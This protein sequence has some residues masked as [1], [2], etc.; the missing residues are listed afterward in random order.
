MKR[1]QYL[2]LFL[3]LLGFISF[4]TISVEIRHFYNPNGSKNQEVLS[5]Q[6]PTQLAARQ[7]VSPSFPSVPDMPPIPE[8][9][10]IAP[11]SIPSIP[12]IPAPE[13]PPMPEIPSMPTVLPPP[14]PEPPTV[15]PIEPPT[16]IIPEA[17]DVPSFEPPTPPSVEIP[18]IPSVPS[19]T[20]P[21]ITIPSAP[22]MPTAPEAPKPIEPY[23]PISSVFDLKLITAA[24]GEALRA[25][26]TIYFKAA[27]PS[28][29][30]L[31]VSYSSDGGKTW[32]PITNNATNNGSLEWATRN[33]PEG[34]NYA[35]KI[36]AKMGSKVI[37]KTTPPFIIDRT[38]PLR[39]NIK[40]VTKE[41]TRSARPVFHWGA[42]TDELSGV[43]HYALLVDYKI[44]ADRLSK[45]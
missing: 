40:T 14:P 1:Q 19:P 36:D 7:P 26:N 25:D 41:A 6:T 10:P 34:T 37:T 15:S 3:S 27:G 44:V 21:D 33:L 18:P 20:I 31:D 4:L 16:I 30:T 24:E 11:P 9:D 23:N 32:K 5:A 39:F 43:S 8:L 2:P 17:P 22:S 29:I 42:A 35:L 13:L 28:K 38:P 12:S 45:T